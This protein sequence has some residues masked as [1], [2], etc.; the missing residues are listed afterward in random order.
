MKNVLV[1]WPLDEGNREKLRQ[2]AG[3]DFRIHFWEKSEGRDA[4]IQAMKEAHIILG[5]PM[6]QDLC[7]C[8]NLEWV[9]LTWSGVDS[10]LDN[11]TVPPGVK[12]S[13]MTGFYGPVI[14]EHLLGLILALCRRLPEYYAQQKE[15]SWNLLLHDKT[16]EGS[17]VLILGAGDIG[18]QLAKRLR[19]MVGSIVGMRRVPRDF[20]D[21]YDEMIT[22]GQLEDYLPQADVV[23][24]CLPK[25]RE[26]NHLI[27]EK[28][29]RLMKQ[30]AI[31][32]NV[33]RG[34]LIDLDELCAVLDEGRLW[35]VGLDVTQPEP[36]PKGHPLWDKPRTI[37][38][39]HV[40]GNS[41]GPDSPTMARMSDFMVENFSNYIHGRQV[42]NLV[43]FTTGYRG[44]EHQK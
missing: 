26:T 15:Q 19:P 8:E 6:A 25:T 34:N 11:G 18:T 3:A 28:Q 29:L 20:P 9:Q 30:D 14:S 36:L 5:D 12:M 17:R 23:V 31:L 38:T 33:G 10:F 37:I 39:P 21:C 2:E 42:L 44:A 1:L 7:Y 22:A 41:F 13:N 43:D 35:G 32:V 4:Y 27:G 16:L 40:S 24:C